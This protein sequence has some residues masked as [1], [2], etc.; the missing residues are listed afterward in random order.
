MV[1]SKYFFERDFCVQNG[2]FESFDIPWTEY[3]YKTAKEWNDFIIA[4]MSV[5]EG[6]FWFRY[7]ELLFRPHE[8]LKKIT[9]SL[10]SQ[11]DYQRLALS[12]ENNT[13]EKIHKSMEKAFSYNTFVRKAQSGDWVNHFSQKDLHVFHLA[14]NNAMKLLGYLDRTK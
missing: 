7:E 13:K 10:Q 9:E 5:E 2:I 4:W 12:I 11:V 6:Q 3:V 8:T 1:V 14:A